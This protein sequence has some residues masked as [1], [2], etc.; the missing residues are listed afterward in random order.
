MW[1]EYYRYINTEKGKREG[2][3]EEA[4]KRMRS[5]LAGERKRTIRVP[6][7]KGS[8]ELNI[9]P[10]DDWC[11]QQELDVHLTYLYSKK[12]QDAEICGRYDDLM[13]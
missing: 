8:V 10:R 4:A 6:S 3:S 12:L 2:G 7:G 5:D 11:F 9:I 13:L 1:F